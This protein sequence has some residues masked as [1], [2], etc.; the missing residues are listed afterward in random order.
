MQF[1]LFTT[2]PNYLNAS[3]RSNVT[4]DAI[5]DAISHTDGN[6]FLGKDFTKISA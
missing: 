3:T 4:S 1:S 5:S 2:D 6:I